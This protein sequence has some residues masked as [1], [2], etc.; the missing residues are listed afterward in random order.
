MTTTEAKYITGAH[1]FADCGMGNFWTTFREKNVDRDF[2]KIKE[3]GFTHIILIL[4]WALFQ[5]KIEDQEL[6][7]YF[8]NRLRFLFESA[9]QTGL[10]VI[11]RLGYLWEIHEV[12]V[13]TYARYKR[14]LVDPKIQNAWRKYIFD[15]Y[16]VVSEYENYDFSFLSWEDTF[17]P[18]FRHPCDEAPEKKME[19]PNLSAFI[20]YLKSKHEIDDLNS[21]YSKDLKSWNDI[22]IP[23]FND[24][25]IM[26]WG[27]FFDEVVTDKIYNMT[28]ASMPDVEF[29]SRIDTNQFLQKQGVR[30]KIWQKIKPGMSRPV[31]YFHANVV[32]PK[33]KSITANEALSALNLVLDQYA[34]AISSPHKVFLDQFNFVTKN[35]DYSTFAAIKEDELCEF[36]LRSQGPLKSKSSGYALWGYRDWIDDKCMNGAF[37]FHDLRWEGNFNI[38]EKSGQKVAVLN[39]GELIKQRLVQPMF[40]K[41]NCLVEMHAE[42]DAEVDVLVDSEKIADFNLRSGENLLKRVF[43]DIKGCQHVSIICIKGQISL[44]RVGLFTNVFSSGAYTIDFEERETLEPIRKLNKTLCSPLPL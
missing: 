12:P 21:I 34:L 15:I 6:E 42:S 1:Y 22:E 31:T 30:P 43:S 33:N 2:S 26:A 20:E 27:N 7:V 16:S 5:P 8:I 25:L 28:L 19:N 35:P 44:L 39:E 11:L 17:W 40:R 10:K 14:I 4:P 9:F 18:L 32:G 41:I 3:D 13:K 38:Q 24:P 36:I 23:K 29:E 37:E